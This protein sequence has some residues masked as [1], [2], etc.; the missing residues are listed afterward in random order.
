M[1]MLYS[2]ISQLKLYAAKLKPNPEI[3]S[4]Y[5]ADAFNMD[6]LDRELYTDITFFDV[7]HP[8]RFTLLFPDFIPTLHHC[9][10]CGV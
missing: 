6:T 2:S 1:I 8:C 7:R 10:S 9:P 5:Q 4:T 3:D